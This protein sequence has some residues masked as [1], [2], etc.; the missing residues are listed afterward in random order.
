MLFDPERRQEMRRQRRRRMHYRASSLFDGTVLAAYP[1]RKPTPKTIKRDKLRI[2]EEGV[3]I[4]WLGAG[5]EVSNVQHE[6]R[7]RFMNIIANRLNMSPGG[8]KPA[9]QGR[10]RSGH[11]ISSSFLDLRALRPCVEGT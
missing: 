3:A 4:E 8:F 10:V 6:N 5:R 11:H 1:I 7:F 2:D 9:T